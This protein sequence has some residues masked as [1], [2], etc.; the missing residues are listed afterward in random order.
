MLI[1]G[2]LD[3]RTRLAGHQ[4]STKYLKAER[5]IAQG[6]RIRILGESDFM[7]IVSSSNTAN[8]LRAV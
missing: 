4:M 6:Q 1:V 3:V 2:D 7:R 8:E 5:L